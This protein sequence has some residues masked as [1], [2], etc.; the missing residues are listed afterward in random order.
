MAIESGLAISAVRKFRKILRDDRPCSGALPESASILR[1]RQTQIEATMLVLI[2]RR[3]GGGDVHRSTNVRAL[4]DAYRSYVSLRKDLR[5]AP[6][7][8]LLDV[9]EAWVLARDLRTG[10]LMTERCPSCATEYVR[11]HLH[12]QRV[13]PGC[14]VCGIRY[15]KASREGKVRNQ[16]NT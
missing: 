2:Y 16:G 1:S 10:E 11:A 14:P 8:P 4:L 15:G 7:R 9:N 5:G 13:A 12:A 3:Y 6:P